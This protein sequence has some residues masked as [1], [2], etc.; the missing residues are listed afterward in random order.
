MVIETDLTLIN[1]SR[2]CNIYTHTFYD[3]ISL[4]VTIYDSLAD[5]SIKYFYG[6]FESEN[7]VEDKIKI[8]RNVFIN[9][10]LIPRSCAIFEYD[11]EIN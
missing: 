5:T 6:I 7:V 9:F 1:D 8:I 10:G 3:D 11:M 2:T 4:F